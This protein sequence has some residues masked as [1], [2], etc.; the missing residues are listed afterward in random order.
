MLI[1]KLLLSILI[2]LSRQVL[3]FRFPLCVSKL[4]L[5]LSISPSLFSFSQL[6]FELF[7]TLIFLFPTVLSIF[8][9]KLS[10]FFEHTFSL[11]A[12][13]FKI[14]L[15]DIQFCCVLFQVP[16]LLTICSFQVSKYSLRTLSEQLQPLRSVLYHLSVIGYLKLQFKVNRTQL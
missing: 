8:T 4:E 1:S 2:V 16:F 12:H 7:S 10:Q 6:A 5:R 11:S 15:C 14:S 3:K 9:L 13:F